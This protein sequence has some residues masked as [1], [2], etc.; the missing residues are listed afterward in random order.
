MISLVS[1]ACIVKNESEKIV[2]TLKPFVDKKFK[3]I[4]VLDTGSTDDTCDKISELSSNITIKHTK[5]I[6][7]S[8][9]RNKALDLVKEEF[10]D[11][12]FVLMID[13]EWYCNNL[14]YLIYFCINNIDTLFDQFNVDILID[15]NT[16][17]S[18]SCL[19]R[20]SGNSR[21]KGG[22]HEIAHGIFGGSVPEFRINVNQTEYGLEKTRKRNLEFDIPFFLALET[23]T[24]EE[25]FYL[26]QSYH[27]IQDYEN[28][29]IY[30][31]ELVN[32]R[33][34]FLYIAN[35]RLGEIFFLNEGYDTALSFYYRAILDNPKRFE[36]YLKIAQIFNGEA[37]YGMAKIAYGLSLP[38]VNK[39]FIDYKG[40][41]YHRYVELIKGCLNVKKYSEGLEVL[42]SYK[43]DNKTTELTEELTFYESLL[44][45]KIVILI[46]TSPGYEEYNRIME[47]Y[48]SSF[49]IEFYFYSYSSQYTEITKVEHNI[50]IPG[51]ETFIPG[52]LNKTID[53]LK[54]FQDY[55]Y[56][57]RLNSTTFV[58][59][60]KVVF[61]NESY[62]FNPRNNI[63]YYGYMNSVSLSQND[64]Y[65]VT[66]DFLEQY[67]SFPFVSGKCII[68]SREAIKYYLSN[69][70][71]I[72]VMDDISLALSFKDKYKI[73]HFN[74]VSDS[75]NSEVVMTICTSVE[76]MEEV[77]K[78]YEL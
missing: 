71:N 48:L 37:K 53:V 43:I 30:Y 12:K 26:A 49:E 2:S 56:V 11:S 76:M 35:Y 36:P 69:Q 47:S 78:I 72:T 65:G 14:D 6:N 44:K 58:D 57:M 50:Y 70:I 8:Q 3:N 75:V 59:L 52:I 25:T 17:N 46:L 1:I 54:M 15:G 32:N 55:D 67:G 10:T 21:Y 38:D 23:R 77:I 31:Y 68:L 13:C 41:T 29:C 24:D 66:E 63:D 61:G 74:S 19:F 18:M 28:A 39:I 4:L 62:T 42:N 9:A 51:E 7:F 45:R 5:F 73:E 27:N 33:K 16:L 22:I 64:K 20:I 60:N 34:K 40:Y